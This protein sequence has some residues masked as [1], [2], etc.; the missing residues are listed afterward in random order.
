MSNSSVV[1][2]VSTMDD[3]ST[4]VLYCEMR[5]FIRPDSS[6]IW[7]GPDGWRITDGMEKY[8]I[9]FSSGSPEAA[10]NGSNTLVPSRVSTLTITN[11]EPSDA[12][13]YS[14]SVNGTTEVV[15]MEL[16]VNG[17]NRIDNVDTTTLQ[18]IVVIL[19]SLTATLTGLLT[20]TVIAMFSCL[21]HARNKFRKSNTG[22]T[23]NPAVIYDYIQNHNHSAHH[24]EVQPGE[25]VSDS[26]AESSA[27]HGM[28][29]D[30]AVVKKNEAYGVAIDGIGI[31]IMERNIAYGTA[32][33]H[34]N[35]AGGTHIMV[36]DGDSDI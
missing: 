9:T 10:A 27:N 19:S 22:D 32:V 30:D 11:P 34:K 23:S 25:L 36:N 5:A 3:L 8:D 29:T 26:A 2:V 31:D 7:E 4:V 16:R 12:G 33:I 20:I 15:T 18:P 35:S 1:T 17:T 6:L 28:G 24:N 21:V 13:T 14:C